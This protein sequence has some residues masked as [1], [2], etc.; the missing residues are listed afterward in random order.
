MFI[1]GVLKI[2]CDRPNVGSI[3]PYVLQDVLKLLATRSMLFSQTDMKIFTRFFQ[4]DP[5]FRAPPSFLE[6]NLRLVKATRIKNVR[7]I[8]IYCLLLLL[9]FLFVVCILILQHFSFYL[10]IFFNRHVGV[11]RRL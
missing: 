4:H 2:T 10:F 11:G 1:P 3:P 5:K 7:K 9:F 8:S 6:L